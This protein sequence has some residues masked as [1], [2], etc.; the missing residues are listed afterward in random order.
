MENLVS[1]L[2]DI[3]TVTMTLFAVIDIL[4]SVPIILNLRARVGSI[5]SEKA[6][7]VCALIMIGFV[8]LGEGI[9]SLVGIN[10]GSFAVAGAFV[11]FFFSLE[12]TLGIQLF[13]ENEPSTASIVPLAFPLIAGAG[14]LTTILSLRAQYSIGVVIIGIII[15]LVLVYLVLKNTGKISKLLGEGGIQVVRKIFGIILMAMAVQLFAGNIS[16]L[17]K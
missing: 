9:L 16:G 2:K 8:F 5:E 15:N 7:L 10:V 13:R 6:T 12:M 3:L 11:L 14:S 17:I 1:Q 4:G